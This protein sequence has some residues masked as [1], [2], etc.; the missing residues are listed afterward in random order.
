MVAHALNPS[1]WEAEAGGFLS[2]R[3]AWSTE[4]VPGQPGLYKKTLSQKNTNKKTQRIPLF[5]WMRDRSASFFRK[6]DH[7]CSYGVLNKEA[8]SSQLWTQSMVKKSGMWAWG[9]L[10]LLSLKTAL[11]GDAAD[12]PLHPALPI[13]QCQ[14]CFLLLIS[15]SSSLS[16]LSLF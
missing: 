6:S 13:H 2:S 8:T 12:M 11:T 4:W 3:P 7:K 5:L 16:L 15:P 14:T 10:K 1:T 9:L